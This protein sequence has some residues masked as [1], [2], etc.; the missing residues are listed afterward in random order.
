MT[1]TPI[2]AAI[3]FNPI[4]GAISAN[5]EQIIQQ[6]KNNTKADII[7]FPELSLTGYPPEDL[8]YRP[9]LYK[10]VGHFLNLIATQ[11]KPEQI[12]ILGH[13]CL[14]DNKCYN[15]LSIIQNQQISGHY[16]KQALPNYATFDEQ[17][18]FHAANEPTILI[19]NN[20]KIGLLICEDIWTDLVV[21]QTL[22]KGAQL[23]LVSNASPYSIHKQ[24]ERLKRVQTICV[25]NHCSVLYLNCVG[26]QDELVFDGRSFYMNAQGECEQMALHCKP[27][28]LILG[29]TR[30]KYSENTS[31]E[32]YEVLVLGIRDYVDKNH[33]PGVLIGLSGGIDSALTLALAVDALGEERV[34]AVMLPSRHTSTMSLEDA[35]TEA[36]LLGCHYETLSIEKT[37]QAF[38]D[39]LQ[40]NFSG[41]K[42]D[43]T[44]ENIQARCRGAILMALS[45]KTGNMVLTTSNKSEMAVGYSTLYGDMVGG[46]APLKDIY[47]TTVYR[48]AHYRNE[49]NRV[50][51]ERVLS[52][53]PSAEL[54]D[55]QTDQD[56]LPDY[57]I[58]DQ[59]IEHIIHEQK[60]PEQI[61]RLGYH[62]E[63][64]IDV[65]NR[66]YRNEY[67]RRQAPIGI[68]VSNYGFGRDRRYPI[69]S[70]YCE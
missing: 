41:L 62:R 42:Q 19:W 49:I 13:P 48:L 55:N 20:L 30:K 18:Y 16:R 12:V 2:I 50:I 3:Q 64:V 26:G 65:A 21:N 1:P 56:T 53:A 54:A 43:V 27:D 35:E 70:S 45:N 5:S 61:I 15:Q 66:I 7:L 29:E 24:D 25:Q 44:E 58:L 22:A 37:Y 23:L 9:E 46:F 39:T 40:S 59:L 34:H 38:L 6:I 14:V 57:A 32:L 69:T 67:K 10:Q 52:R 17:R 4:V 68:R 51:P 28:R 31:Q 11:C 63:M 36:R 60:T 47:K 33:F 8:L